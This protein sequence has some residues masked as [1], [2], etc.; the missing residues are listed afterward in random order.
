MSVCAFLQHQDVPAAQMTT[1]SLD[2][3]L[4]PLTVP[5][6]PLQLLAAVAPLPVILVF[7]IPRPSHCAR[8]VAPGEAPPVVWNVLEMI[9][10]MLAR[11]KHVMLMAHVKP[12]VRSVGE[13]STTSKQSTNSTSLSPSARYVVRMGFI[14][15][16]IQKQDAL[17]SEAPLSLTLIWTKC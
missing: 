2:S 14:C 15:G 8:Q 3:A 1:P 7:Q 13:G 17:V 9:I 5:L 16:P 12:Q 4:A 11:P 10:V 6:L